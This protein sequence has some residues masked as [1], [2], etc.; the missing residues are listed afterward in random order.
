MDNQTH[1]IFYLLN[2]LMKI[3]NSCIGAH[4]GP[5]MLTAKNLQCMRALL[6]LAHCHG[7][8]LGTSWHLVLTTLQVQLLFC[9]LSVYVYFQYFIFCQYISVFLISMSTF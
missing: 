6:S 8:I 7:G 4:Q 9:I 1:I 2:S 3:S 5:V